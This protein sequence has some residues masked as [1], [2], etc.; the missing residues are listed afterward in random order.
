MGA[1]P[2]PMPMQPGQP[3]TP[4]QSTPGSEDPSEGETIVRAEILKRIDDSLQIER[5]W[6]IQ[7]QKIMQIYR[8]QLDASG[9]SVKGKSRFNSLNS[10]T[11]I[12]LPSLFSLPPKPDIRSRAAVSD[13]FIDQACE[14]MQKSTEVILQDQSAFND[15]KAAVQEVLLPGR[16]TVRVRWDP[17]VEK[18]T[19]PGPNGTTLDVFEK[20]LDQIQID[21]VYWEDFTHEHTPSWKECGWVAFRHLMTEQVFMGYFEQVQVV[22]QWVA[23]GKKGDIFKWTDKTANRAREYTG[24]TRSSDRDTLQDTI[25]K[26]MVWEFWD[27]S[28]REII[29]ICQDMNGNVLTID[30]D[31]L[32]LRKFFPCPEP[33]KA[34][35]TTDQQLPVPEY[36]IYQDLAAE[37]DT[38]SERIAQIAK[39]IKVVGAY[40]GAQ[41]Q[42]AGILKSEDGEM[43]AVNG[44]DIEF[45][46]QKHVWVLSLTDLVQ[47]LQALYQARQEAKQAMYEVTG[48]SD[49]VRGQSRASETLGAQRIKSQFAALRIEDRKHAVEF[50]AQGIIDII[51]ELVAQKFSPESIFFYTGIQPFPETMQ[52]LQNDAM[53]ISRIDVE[54]DSTVAPDEAAEQEAMSGMLQ[55]LGFV[56]Q[57]IGPMVMQ[58]IM[59]LP[60]AIELVKLA[61]SPF[62]N[63]RKI[64]ELLDKAMAMMMGGMGGAPVPPGSPPGAPPGQPQPAPA[65]VPMQ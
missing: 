21:H 33:L 40:N 26:A 55:A 49:I 51:A 4:G 8:G 58:G 61:V 22:Q 19:A 18:K 16:G 39:R 11:S 57:Q 36:I 62:K 56:L 15:I 5:D 30:Q 65:G 37:I 7:G 17:I 60:I 24:S 20:L 23:A 63:A 9:S 10:N 29:W 34:V 27:K 28:T 64:N 12:L 53:R 2:T 42:L 13:Q 46:L 32:K 38:L 31:T 48:I 45:D 43:T 14:I 44:L 1:Q 25:M 35:T 59:P 52:I 3:M 41:E 47:A 54:T 6:R 50:F